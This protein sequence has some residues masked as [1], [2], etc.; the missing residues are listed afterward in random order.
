MEIF[1]KIATCFQQYSGMGAQFLLFLCAMLFLAMCGKNKKLYQVL[2]Q[3]T[4]FIIALMVFPITA[5]IIMEY[6]IGE[7][8]YWRMFWLLPIP[9]VIA[10]AGVT[11]RE[12]G[13]NKVEKTGITAFFLLLILLSGK[14][15]YADGTIEKS[16]NPEKLPKQVIEVCDTL[17]EDALNNGIET[18]RVVVPTELLSYVRQ[19]DATILMP[20]GRNAIKEE[21]LTETREEIY[22]IMKLDDK[23]KMDFET[24]AE[25]LKKEGCNYLVLNKKVATPKLDN[26]GY[27]QVAQ[28][29]SYIIYRFD[30]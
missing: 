23:K 21:G 3:Y 20:Y 8:V 22:E 12:R 9:F 18:R 2:N 15:V 26:Y 25:D 10:L 19:Y 7:E 28:T 17:T 11:L 5:I 1:E 4:G 14:C 16:Y 13:K 24:L 6:C 29:E 30:G 27:Y